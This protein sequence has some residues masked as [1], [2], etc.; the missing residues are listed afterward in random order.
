MT[1]RFSGALLISICLISGHTGFAQ[2]SK[3]IADKIQFVPMD[4][5]DTKVYAEKKKE[6]Q[7]IFFR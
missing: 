1:K 5:F 4:K 6:F 7:E 2:D 3:L